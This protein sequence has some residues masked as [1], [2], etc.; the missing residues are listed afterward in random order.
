MTETILSIREGILLVNGQLNID[1]AALA[2]VYSTEGSN[3]AERLPQKREAA[4]PAVDRPVNTS[5]SKTQLQ[6]TNDYN[7]RYDSLTTDEDFFENL[8]DMKQPTGRHR[9]FFEDVARNFEIQ[10]ISSMGTSLDDY[11]INGEKLLKDM[12][13]ADK[14]RLHHQL[15]K[16]AFWLE[17]P[18][19]GKKEMKYNRELFDA[20]VKLANARKCN[21]IRDLVSCIG[22]VEHESQA[23]GVEKKQFLDDIING[24]NNRLENL[25][26]DIDALI[27][28]V[29]HILEKTKN[30]LG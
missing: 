29:E 22:I 27:L 12:S 18:I 28:N 6:K 7:T 2:Q 23:N 21:S 30:T 25:E 14:Q 8:S 24:K 16:Y 9:F 5:Y 15:L 3:F 19:T 10:F 20:G 11:E 26:K 17:N 13:L 4:E 1:G